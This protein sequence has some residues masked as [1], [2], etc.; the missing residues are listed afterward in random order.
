MGPNSDSKRTLSDRIDRL[1]ADHAHS[2]M[3]ID[4][5]ETNIIHANDAAKVRRMFNKGLKVQQMELNALKREMETMKGSTIDTWSNHANCGV[6]PLEGTTG[7]YT[8]GRRLHMK[9]TGGK[10]TMNK[11]MNTMPEGKETMKKKTMNR[12]TSDLAN[13]FVKI[14]KL[15]KKEDVIINKQGK[16]A[17]RIASLASKKRWAENKNAQYWLRATMKARKELNLKGF[18][19]IGGNTAVGKAFLAK[20]QAIYKGLK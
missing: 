6:S 20:A 5:M 13:G 10:E 1:E 16:R 11:T 9:T 8:K 12:T 18:V 2:R 19:P 17:G 7:V 4:C 3:R 14:V 15:V